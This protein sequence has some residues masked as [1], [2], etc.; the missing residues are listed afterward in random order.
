MR[1]VHDATLSMSKSCPLEEE[2]PQRFAGN[3]MFILLL[4]TLS[5]RRTNLGGRRDK[6]IIRDILMKLVV[7]E[8]PTGRGTKMVTIGMKER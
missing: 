5:I 2:C 7:E 1:E 8:T 6:T 4:D 3:L